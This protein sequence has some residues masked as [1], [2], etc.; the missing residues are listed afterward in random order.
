[1]TTINDFEHFVNLAQPKL[2]A[3]VIFATDD[4]FAE[5]EALIDPKE[6]VF[7]KDKFTDR[8]KWM[9]GW[10]SRRKRGPG[11]DYCVVRIC[12]GQIYGVNID[13]AHFS[14]NYPQ[15][16]RLEACDSS[17]D[18]DDDTTWH[19]LV[20]KS[21]LKGDSD[22]IF[23]IDSQA[24]WTHLRLHIYPDGGVARLRV[25]G[26]ILKDWSAVSKH[27][28]LDLA[29]V[30]NGAVAVACSDMH[31]GSMWNL[32]YPQR[33]QNMGD[34]WETRRRRGEGYDWAVIKLAHP[35]LVKFIHID[36]LHF[37]GNFPAT[38]AVRSI[39]APGASKKY[40]SNPETAWNTL[41]PKSTMQAD[42]DHEFR[43]EINHI[44]MTSHVK[45]E[46]HPDGGVGRL[47][48]YGSITNP[49]AA[50]LVAEPLTAE[51][52]ASFGEVIE[53]R[54]RDCRTINKGYADRYENLANLDVTDGGHPA[55]SIFRA[56]P[57]ELPFSITSMECHPNA[58]QGFI[59]TGNARFLVVVARA[60]KQFDKS[61]IRVFVTNGSQGVNYKRGVWHHFLLVI[62]Q[63][64]DFIVIDRSAPDD[65]TN[66]IQLNAPYPIIAD[67]V[68]E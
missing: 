16:A 23:A 52:F 42:S 2:G 21:P 34:G 62:D 66:E 67:F 7:I 36:T 5:K 24:Q 56:R 26:E 27:E 48:V 44:G 13:T 46:M 54:G 60:A 10:E 49:Q 57:V 29:A 59:P 55:L 37:K 6:P 40:L 3:E 12:R 58:S 45:L 41:L 50:S 38:C 35:G 25:F 4:F 1:M 33:A 31:F 28:V 64:Q 53:T 11:H 39:Y 17:I 9:D 20:E 68:T 51:N 30:E 32:L 63:Q 18:P 19:E 15:F 8:G 22:N 65:N 47:R 14:G 61:D 43:N